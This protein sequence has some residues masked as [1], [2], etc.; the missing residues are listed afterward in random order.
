MT[1]DPNDP[2]WDR[3]REA[4]SRIMA[5]TM[6]AVRQSIET[7]M[8]PTIQRMFETLAPALEQQNKMLTMALVESPG[9]Q[10]LSEQLDETFSFVTPEFVVAVAET[11][12]GRLEAI[13]AAHDDDVRADL[14]LGLVVSV[15]AFM[16][17]AIVLINMDMPAQELFQRMVDMITE[18]LVGLAIAGAISIYRRG[19]SDA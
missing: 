3:K 2:G 18:V 14:R 8:A 1:L 5:P 17:T 9:W 16:G 15:A 11:N 6:E 10:R 13:A 19:R 7:S 12:G 4:L